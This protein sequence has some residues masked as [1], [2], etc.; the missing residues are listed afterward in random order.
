[1]SELGVKQPEKTVYQVGFAVVAAL[2]FVHVGVLERAMKPH[3][4]RV[5]GLSPKELE[6]NERDFEMC[7]SKARMSALGIF[8]QGVF[9]L[10][11]DVSW[12]SFVHWGGAI[13]VMIGATAHTQ[14]SQDMYKRT[15]PHSALLQTPG[16][17][18]IASIRTAMSESLGFFIGGILF[19]VPLLWQVSKA[20]D[21]PAN[22]KNAAQQPSMPSALNLMGAVQWLLIFRI[23]AVYISYGFD[24]YYM[25]KFRI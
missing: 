19:L 2:V 20:I 18:W 14:A 16:M 9:T 22:Q 11:H 3:F 17:K 1:M 25:F 7:V 24:F 15:A 5:Q 10:E 4:V 12:Q 23:A 8:L 6:D 13:I 21:T